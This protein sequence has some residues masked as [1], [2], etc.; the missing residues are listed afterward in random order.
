MSMEE[1]SRGNFASDY[2]FHIP[3]LDLSKE[4]SLLFGCYVFGLLRAEESFLNN[5]GR[6]TLWL[7]GKL[8]P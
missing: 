5:P 4:A 6:S 3:D 8:V 2:K 7:G 1:C